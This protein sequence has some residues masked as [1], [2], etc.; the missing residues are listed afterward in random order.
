MSTRAAQS[1]DT[2]L[3][4]LLLDWGAD[5]FIATDNGDTALTACAG[6]GWV[7]QAPRPTVPCLV[8]RQP[9]TMAIIKPSDPLAIGRGPVLPL[10]LVEP[11]AEQIGC[12]GTDGITPHQ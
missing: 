7:V 2:E 10:R 5:P 1:S 6:I 11:I 12:S 3:M 8:D 4:Q 9:E